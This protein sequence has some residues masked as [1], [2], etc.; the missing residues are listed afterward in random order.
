MA[1]CGKGTGDGYNWQ[2][3]YKSAKKQVIKNPDEPI[4]SSGNIHLRKFPKAI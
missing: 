3:S 1:F 4:S 2:R